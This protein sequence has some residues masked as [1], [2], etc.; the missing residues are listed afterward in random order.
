MSF[1][2]TLPQPRRLPVVAALAALLLLFLLPPAPARAE[3]TAFRQALASAV[4]G[5]P[6][7]AAFYGARNYDPIWVSKKDRK[8]RRAFLAVLK[9]APAHGLPSGRYDAA[10]V[11][12]DFSRLRAVPKRVEVEI[13]TSRRFLQYAR[14]I[15]S[16][17][18]TPRR[19]DANMTL[20]PVRRDPVGLLSAF[21][22]SSPSGFLAK[23]PPQT[24]GYQRLLKEK[25][26]IQSVAARGG[27]G[28]KVPA[29]TLKPGQSG[30]AVRVL[31]QRLAAMGYARS[32]RGDVYDETLKQ[33]V[34]RFQDAHG[35]NRDG[36]VGK[37]TM[38]A[39]NTTAATRLMQAVI[40]LERL[41][42]LNKPLG[43]RH[44]IVNEAAF[45]VNV[46]DRGRSI[47]ESRVVVGKPGRWRTPE[48]ED[49]MT[50]MIVN[51][52]WYVPS[53]IAGI[54]YLPLLK[55]NPNALARQDM[56]MTDSSG[57]VVNP[58]SVDF[59]KY[60]KGSFP[61][62]LRQK[63]SGGNALGKV[64]FLF[65]N[66]HAIYLHDTPA[67]RL[68][69]YDRRAFSHGC[70]RVQKPMQLAY[71]L[72]GWQSANPKQLFDAT[73]AT[74]V[75]TRIDLKSPIPIY[76]VYRTAWVA[77]DGTPNYRADSYNVDGKLYGAMKKAG[78]VLG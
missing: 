55:Q 38:A 20:R 23:L 9:E 29:A 7:L 66:K 40:G 43:K 63:P 69:G 16:G 56:E 52:S 22:K 44:I 57:R 27:W 58:G 59:S 45:T 75:E 76:L 37:Q 5:D 12:S 11:R 21:S 78:V 1:P 14:D 53:S 68:F 10:A 61:F 15:Q 49:Q 50:H 17:I 33:A 54:E 32:A 8:R 25:A 60:T 4:A 3:S 70:V 18:V 35:L 71:T 34:A 24:A 73:L 6:V 65:P 26:R 47:Y 30:A 36:I 2:S 64:K 67:K 41:R 31:R 51:P 13:R 42:W 48:F 46:Y 39:I 74:G 62:S 19:V 28:P 77:S 72:L